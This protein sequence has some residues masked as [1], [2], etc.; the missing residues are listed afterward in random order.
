LEE[1]TDLGDEC[2]EDGLERKAG[3]VVAARAGVASPNDAAVARRDYLEHMEGMDKLKDRMR[4]RALRVHAFPVDSDEDVWGCVDDDASGVVKVVHLVRHGQGFHNL[5]AEIYHEQGRIWAQ[6]VPSPCNPYILPELLDCPLT[7]TGRQ[8]ALALQGELTALC[9]SSLR[10]ELVVSSPHT[11]ALQTAL[12]AF[13]PLLHNEDGGDGATA[14]VPFL[15]HEMVREETGVHECDRRR[16][17]ERLRREFSPR[18]NFDLL[19]EDDDIFRAGA[20]ES[21]DEV[22]DRVYEFLEWLEQRSERVVAVSTHSAWLLTLL[23]GV[24]ECR[25]ADLRGWFG[26]GEMRSMRFLFVRDQN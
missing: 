18:F 20:R 26:T 3:A 6:F 13:E 22:G 4:R 21:K 5:L 14:P 12:L 8:Q 24:C 11:R 9:L 19:P 23:N 10:P 7:E 1:A 25:D 17:K 16:P 2:K 15:A